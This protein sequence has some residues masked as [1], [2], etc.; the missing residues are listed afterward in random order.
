MHS[1]TVSLPQRFSVSLPP[2]SLL[3]LSHR[4]LRYGVGAPLLPPFPSLRP[5]LFPGLSLPPGLEYG[6][7]KAVQLRSYLSAVSS[8][9]LVFVVGWWRYKSWLTML[10]PCIMSI[11][12]GSMLH[13]SVNFA[14]TVLPAS[15]PPKFG[16]PSTPVSMC[17]TGSLPLCPLQV[18]AMANGDVT[19][20]YVDEMIAGKALLLGC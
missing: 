7:K 18:G 15:L 11:V 12:S 4:T 8:P 16:V 3:S 20:D 10:S 1:V 5:S 19:S 17:L 13:G 14:P 2:Y 6:A 9:S